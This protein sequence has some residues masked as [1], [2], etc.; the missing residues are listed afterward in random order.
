MA[1]REIEPITGEN[2]PLAE[3]DQILREEQAK[4]SPKGESFA[5]DKPVGVSE[6]ARR[7]DH[8]GTFRA[9]EERHAQERAAVERDAVEQSQGY[10]FDSI[11]RSAGDFCGR[12]R[13]A[14]QTGVM[15]PLSTGEPTDKSK[16]LLGPTAGM[17]SPEERKQAAE[18]ELHGNYVL[19]VPVAG[20]EQMA[21]RT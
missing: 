17:L 1:D 9:L 5:V 19:G 6:T 11:K 7:L 8:D 15:A 12:A 10:S 4:G 2:D 21:R 16:G 20:A 14:T 13:E 3:F 18:E